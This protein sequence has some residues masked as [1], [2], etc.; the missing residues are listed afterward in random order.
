VT[1]AGSILLVLSQLLGAGPAVAQDSLLAIRPDAQVGSVEFRFSGSQSFSQAELGTR[2]ALRGRGSLYGL[3]RALGELP[4]V[5]S[6]GRYGFDPVELQK[7]VVRLRQFYR[8]AGFA[9]PH[10]DYQVRTNDP[11]TVVDVSYL[12]DE[13]P[14]AVLRT[15]QVVGPDRAASLV[16]PDSLRPSWGEL[17]TRL[18][19][20]RGQRFGEA[21]L[22]AAQDTLIRWLHDHGYPFAQVRSTRTVDTAQQAVDVGLQADPGPL[23]RIGTITVEGNSSVGDRVVLRELP[24]RTGD[25]YS[26]R[27]MA[28]ARTRLQ[29]VDLLART[30]VDVDSQPAADSTV[31]VRVQVQE[32]RPRLTLAEV[33]YVSEAAG[34]TGRVQWTDPNF[35]GGARSLTASLEAQSGAGAVGT[36]AEQLLRGSLSLTQPYVFVPRLSFVV[37]PYVEYRNDLRDQ[38]VAVGVNAA[39]VHRLAALSSIALEYRFSRR[40]IYEYHFGAV[41]S[42]DIDLLELLA[43]KYPPLVDSLGYNENKSTFALSGSFAE[44]DNLTDPRRGWIVRPTAKITFPGAWSTAQFGR[45]DLSVSRFQPLGRDVVLAARVSAG[46]LYPFGKSVPSEGSDPIFSFIH[47]RDESMTAGG[48]NDVRGW[49]DRKLG[50]KVPDVEAHIVGADTVLTADEYVPIGA[51][52]RVTGSLELRFPTPGMTPAWRTQVFLDAG[53]VWTPDERFSQ[54]VLLPEQTELRWSAGVGLSYQT[55]VGAIGLSLG[56]KLNPS[57]LD[58]R[59]AGKVLDAFVAGE[60]IE[61]VPTD[62]FSRLHLHF[63]FGVAL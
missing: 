35:T 20:R 51:L 28:S 5:P 3:R 31:S 42:G 8:R 63:S 10:V 44:V 29:A 54:T 19:A 48:T 39:L 41:S 60:P 49:G 23:T 30:V 12:I 2:I 61:S 37:G 55:P 33:G 6:P 15:V 40:H 22:A 62:A 9:Q 58:L 17:E 43:L 18:A 26:A 24:F 21:D 53:R 57:P 50:P 27:T 1:R 45:L 56:Y 34:L 7:D 11:G 46:R 36:E 13:G 25:L 52:A 38:S 14:A 4:L 47:L 59:D 32:T 16:L